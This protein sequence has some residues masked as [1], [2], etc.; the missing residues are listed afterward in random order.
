MTGKEAAY[1]DFKS[2]VVS[3][4]MVRS[5][6]SHLSAIQDLRSGVNGSFHELED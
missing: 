1:L 2:H 4:S 3:E 6:G 5:V